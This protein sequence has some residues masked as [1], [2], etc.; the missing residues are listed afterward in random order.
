[1]R[2]H[3]R[4]ALC[5]LVTCLALPVGVAAQASPTLPPSP[6]ASPANAD[7][8]TEV[9][10]RAKEWLHRLQT[11][12]IDRSQLDAAMNSAMTPAVIKQIAADYGPL[13]DPQ[14]FTFI[15]SQPVGDK[16]VVAYV[17]RVALKSATLNEIFAVDKDG[18]IGGIRF[19]LAQ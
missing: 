13:G 12:D 5:A 7:A 6:V 3:V 10:A 15:G 11:G 2:L 8:G 4:A 1:M 9:A 19:A 18:K 16:G 17:Y 14:S